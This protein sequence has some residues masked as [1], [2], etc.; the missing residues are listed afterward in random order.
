MNQDSLQLT[1]TT[2]KPAYRSGEPIEL[3]L[4]LT[5]RVGPARTLEFSNGQ[6]YDFTIADSAG[7]TVWSWS[8]G[9]MFAQMMGT[10]RLAPGESRE[11]RERFTGRLSRGTYRATGTITTTGS[12]PQARTTF[13]VQ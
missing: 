6:R 13:T 8:A 5:N 9:R 10:E 3:L 2:D 11:Y 12:A 4:T 7:A 1:V